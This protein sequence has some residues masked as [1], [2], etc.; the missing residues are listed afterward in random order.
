MLLVGPDALVAAADEAGHLRD[1][2]HVE[3]VAARVHALGA[4]PVR[5]R[6]HDAAVFDDGGQQLAGFH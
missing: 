6:A 3:A 1:S 2:V 5:A 4:Q